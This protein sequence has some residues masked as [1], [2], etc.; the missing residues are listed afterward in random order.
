MQ[1]DI[2][3]LT[4]GRRVFIAVS[5]SV[6]S[7]V[8][9]H[10]IFVTRGFSQVATFVPP[11][12]AVAEKIAKLTVKS[13]AGELPSEK[14]VRVRDALKRGDYA[15]AR[16]I[17]ADVL[18]SSHVEN[19]RFYP[20]SDFINAVADAS[21][22]ALEDRLD[23]WVAQNGNDAIPLLVRAQYYH[24]MGW[25][26]RGSRFS[27]EV[28][29]DHMDAFL[30][31]MS[32]ASADVDAAIRLDDGNPHSF[33]LKLRIMRGLGTM[34]QL[35][36]VFDA[37]VAKH[38]NYYPLYDMVLTTLQPKWGGTIDAMYAFVEQYAGAADEHSPLKLLYVSLYRDLLGTASIVCNSRGGDRETRAQC[39]T[40]AMQDIVTPELR[41]NVMAGLQ[42]YDHSNKY[43]FG[44]A[45]ESIL[46]DMLNTGAGEAYSSSVLQLAA[47]AMHSDT[48]LKED[49]PGH[50]DYMVDKMVAYSWY[51]KGFYDNALT[52]SQE[53]LDDIA[54]AT[55]PSE[56]EKDLAVAGIYEQLAR[57]YDKLHQYADM[58]AYQEAAL[59]LA[60]KT[61][62]EFY[63][64]Y[65]YYRL[66][67]Y[68]N[69]L[70]ACDRTI[71]SEPGNLKARYWRGRVHHELGHLDAEL[72]DLTVVAESE[73]SLRAT[74]AIDISMIHFNRKDVA[75][76][77]AA[78]NKF[79]YLYDPELSGKSN[80]AVGHNNRCYAYMELGE[81]KKALDDCTASLKYGNIPDAYRKQEQLIKRLGTRPNL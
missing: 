7:F 1:L 30:N 81:L 4:A 65:A 29:P 28:L 25:H 31:Y 35:R 8:A 40:S 45:L 72:A 63:I 57:I 79:T 71:E 20:F 43:Q 53:A 21:D 3:I 32:K 41:R 34:K 60:G 12:S 49:D 56:E 47:S 55:F 76:A 66:K 48:Q 69:A 27:R 74:S 42:L 59:G 14:A 64:C 2:S 80:A 26:R 61:S 58:A 37:A 24:D 75:S 5:I 62:Q 13:R 6:A 11:T 18:A 77:L 36:T 33:Y 39:V 73:D 52:K 68:D 70:R 50:N 23:T 17:T 22:P 67:E 19:W 15:T 54:R 51:R 78:L 46:S 9:M 16:Q 10:S 44:L 38:P